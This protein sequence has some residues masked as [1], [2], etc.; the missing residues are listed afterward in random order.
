MAQTNGNSVHP[1]KDKTADLTEGEV[2]VELAVAG[3][4]KDEEG[5]S[6]SSLKYVILLI[7]Y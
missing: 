1:T 2:V 5:E 3:G 6:S 7:R 4:P